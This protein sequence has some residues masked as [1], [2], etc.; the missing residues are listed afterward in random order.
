[1]QCQGIS[2]KIGTRNKTEIKMMMKKV[3]KDNKL[4]NKSSINTG[5]GIYL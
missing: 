3:C 5:I 4:W 2:R 1:M